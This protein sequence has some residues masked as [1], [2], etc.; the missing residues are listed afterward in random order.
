MFTKANLPNES[1]NNSY[2][3]FLLGHSLK[4]SVNFPHSKHEPL[5]R[6]GFGHWDT[7]FTQ[8]VAIIAPH[9]LFILLNTS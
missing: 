8:N 7:I 6:V 4:Q 3:D 5:A 9:W 2:V 1:L